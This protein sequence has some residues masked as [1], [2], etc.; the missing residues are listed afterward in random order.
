MLR[1]TISFQHAF[2]GIWTARTSQLNLRL[3]FL[4]GSLVL[5]AAVY[6]E[7]TIL[8]VLILILTIMVVM[9]TEMCNTALE[10]LADGIS[11]EHREYIKHAKDVAAGA[12]LLSSIFAALIGLIIFVPKII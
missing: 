2:T 9:V 12:V 3:H 5:F 4:L 6:F 7:C 11:F 1:H 10:F 8:E